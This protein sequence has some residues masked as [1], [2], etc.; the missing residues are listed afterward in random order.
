[1]KRLGELAVHA[2]AP[3]ARDVGEPDSIGMAVAGLA[4]QAEVA[5]DDLVQAVSS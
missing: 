4:Q 2:V 3:S 5:V 1:L